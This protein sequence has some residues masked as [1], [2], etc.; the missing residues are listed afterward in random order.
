M[1]YIL[2]GKSQY[3]PIGTALDVNDNNVIYFDCVRVEYISK[4]VEKFMDNKNITT[5]T[6]RIQSNY[7]VMGR[8]FC[9]GFIDFMLNSK[10]LFYEWILKDE[11]EKILLS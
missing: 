3:K 11:C 9:I 1:K 8:Y 6:F 5:N 7:S 10:S 2:M 4:E